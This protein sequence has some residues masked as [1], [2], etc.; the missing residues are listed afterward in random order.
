MA[1]PKPVW[2]KD[3][4]NVAQK[5]IRNPS[6]SIWNTWRK[7]PTKLAVVRAIVSCQ[8]RIADN[9]FGV[10]MTRALSQDWVCFLQLYSLEVEAALLSAVQIYFP[11]R[12]NFLSRSQYPDFWGPPVRNV[13]EENH[14]AS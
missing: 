8:A 3:D 7:S 2:S 12:K 1:L 6:S 14:E 5:V 4:V 9:Y 13:P 10:D 11:P